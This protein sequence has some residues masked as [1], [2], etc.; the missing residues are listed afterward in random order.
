VLKYLELSQDETCL[1][2]DELF[3]TKIASSDRVER[4]AVREQ[5]KILTDTLRTKDT[6]TQ[7]FLD[8]RDDRPPN[9]EE[10]RKLGD[11]PRLSLAS[12]ARCSL[13]WFHGLV[14]GVL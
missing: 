1:E 14:L 3:L 12:F 6:I 13:A 11:D 4:I 10:F 2:S 7:A 9:I 5:A 8:L